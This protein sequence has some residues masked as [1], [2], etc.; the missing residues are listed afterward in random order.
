[1]ITLVCKVCG[2]EFQ[3]RPGRAKS[4]RRKFCGKVCQ[5]KHQTTVRGEKHPGFGK[6]RSLGAVWKMKQGC[7]L[8]EL[9]RKQRGEAHPAWKGGRL[10]R[11]EYVEI[12]IPSLQPA[13]RRLARQMAAKGQHYIREHRL[14]A[15]MREGRPLTKDEIVHHLNGQKQDNR[16]ENLE[17]MPRAK[18]SMEHREIEREL[19]RLRAENRHLKSLL[20]TYQANGA[21]TSS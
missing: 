2:K 4:G 8:R 20:A 19:A 18:H 10:T 14:V 15:A 6:K 17:V 21:T 3:C 13:K 1:M 16:M 5:A 12:Y 9:A 11:G 7:Q